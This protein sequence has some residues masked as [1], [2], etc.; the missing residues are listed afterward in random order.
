MAGSLW[1]ETKIL[2]LAHTTVLRSLVHVPIFRVLV[3]KVG[4]AVGVAARQSLLSLIGTNPVLEL[5][6]VG[7]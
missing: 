3:G 7:F 6:G 4:V 2:H 1:N 5:R